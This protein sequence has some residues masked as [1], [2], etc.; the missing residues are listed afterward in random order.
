MPVGFCSVLGDYAV[1]ELFVTKYP[2]CKRHTNKAGLTALQIAQQ[3]K[4]TRIAE[5]I[6]TGK[7]MSQSLNDHSGEPEQPKH[8][9]ATLMQASRDGHIKTIQ[10]F[11]DQ[12]YE[13]KEQ[14]RQLCFELIQVAKQAKQRQISDLLEPYYK[15]KLKTELASD[16][17]LGGIGFTLSEH[18]KRVLRGFLSGLSTLIADSPIVLDPTD[19]K[20]Y[21]D[22]F[23]ALTSNIAKRSQELQQVTNEH[24]VRKIIEQD[25]INTKQQLTKISEQLEQL[26]ESRDS[27]QARI[28]DTDERLFKQQNLTAIQRKEFMKEKE[29][30]KQQLAIYECS[31]F[32]F[33]RQQE[34]TLTRQKTV[35]FIKGN[36]NLIMFYRTIENR[37]EALFHSALAAQGG[38]LKKETTAKFGMTS[39]VFTMWPTK[40]PIRKYIYR[41]SK[42]ISPFFPSKL[43]INKYQN[44][45]RSGA[46]KT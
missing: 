26:L 15:T 5:L 14:K 19:P 20:T 28:Q 30:H 17:E 46:I 8:G 45:A 4:F 23:S 44:S 31:I 38:Y 35:D 3:L 37:L 43:G 29:I 41:Y 7:T 22:L 34:A 2:A 25:E 24:D 10:E 27:L 12:R 11:I 39:P 32:L 13:S 6:E 9:F 33:Q 1:V 16:M 40:L 21:V 36:A 18:H 42:Q